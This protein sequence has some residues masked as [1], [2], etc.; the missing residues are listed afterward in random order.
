MTEAAAQRLRIRVQAPAVEDAANRAL[1][2]FLAREFGVRSRAVRII[3]GTRAREK[4]VT[5]QAPRAWPAWL[6]LD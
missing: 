4:R 3:S 6:S 1:C 5:V 2:D